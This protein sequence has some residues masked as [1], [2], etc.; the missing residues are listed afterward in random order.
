MRVG[1]VGCGRIARVHRSYLQK[2]PHVELVGVWD[3]DEGARSVFAGEARL[4]SYSTLHEL[5]ECG[6]PDVVHVL[7]PPA[8]HAPLALELLGAGVNVLIEKPFAL[9]TA[10]AD[11]IMAA[12]GRSGCWVTV[13]HNRWFD[14]VVQRAA[15]VLASGRLGRL[16]GVDIFQGADAAEVEKLSGGST[17][18]SVQLPGGTLHNLASHP[19]YLMRRFA[20]PVH[21]LRVVGRKTNGCQLEEVRL[22]ALGEQAPA[23]VSMSLWARPFMNRLTLLGTEASVEVNLNNM[24]LIERRPR[25]L[26]KLLGKVWP[27]ISEATQLL[28]A[29]VQNGAA[30][31]AGRQRFYPGIGAHLGALYERVAAGELPP[32]TA[33]E[34]RDVVAW[35]DEILIQCGLDA[36]RPA[37]AA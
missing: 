10:E 25:S 2:L 21:D 11:A 18:W 26:P 30:F 28:W 27:N 36:S 7:T 23:C 14:P 9:A 3:T 4:S 19:L 6:R 22:V 5:L 16:V 8:T 37:P 13:D 35:Y 34:G 12:A 20:G 32:V 33:T 1:L 24:T 29:T 15:E 31:A 17:H